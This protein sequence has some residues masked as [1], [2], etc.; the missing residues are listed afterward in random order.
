MNGKPTQD[1]DSAC[2]EPIRH[3]NH[4]CSLTEAGQFDRVRELCSSPKYFCSSC[5]SRAN[6]AENL[7]RPRKLENEI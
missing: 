5:R 4:L 2:G 6:R 3:E 7:C 1:G